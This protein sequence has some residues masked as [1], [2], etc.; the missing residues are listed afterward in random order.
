[1]SEKKSLYD[2]VAEANQIEK[3]LLES[4]GELD[5]GI[6]AY[7]ASVDADLAAKADGYHA[8][9]GRAESGAEYFKK[10]ADEFYA[11]AK[12]LSTFQVRLKDRIK[13]AMQAM[14]KTEVAGEDVVFKLS[15][16]KPSLVIE[17]ED[18]LPK[19]FVMVVTEH[20]PDKNAIRT[21]LE[22]GFEVPGASLKESVSLRH[23]VN[24]KGKTS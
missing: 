16:V 6:E 7:I 11:A 18:H 2:I 4:G 17:N 3:M 5:H 14:G 21:A 9:M 10:R 12:V 1:M 20:V 15:R 24:K 19:S 8:V 22:Q 23:S 13:A